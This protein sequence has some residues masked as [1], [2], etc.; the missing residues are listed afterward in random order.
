MSFE[1]FLKRKLD[2]KKAAEEMQTADGGAGG[3]R[4]KWSDLYKP[5]ADPTTGNAEVK[6]RFLPAK[7][8][9]GNIFVTRY[10]HFFKGDNGWVV[11]DICPTTHG[12]PCP[13]CDANSKLWNS[14][15][16]EEKNIARKRKRRKAYLF[17]VVV[18]ND[19]VQPKYNGTVQTMEIGY[20]IFQKI[21]AAMK[22]EFE[23]E[24]PKNPFDIFGGNNFIF[25]MKMDKAK[26][27]ITYEDSKFE[28]KAT[29]LFDGDKEKLKAVFENMAD[30]NF[31]LQPE[32]TQEKK[33][34]AKITCEAYSK[35]CPEIAAANPEYLKSKGVKAPATDFSADIPWDVSESA[36]APA[37]PAPTP[38]ETPAG[39][40]ESDM[41]FFKR[42]ASEAE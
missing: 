32:P 16:E 28:D 42:L 25:R 2:P 29:D 38:E 12:Q 23:S 5:K 11:M 7:E 37:A 40:E 14:G 21:M 15:D 34:W 30:L 13:I 27:Q 41:D 19:P 35:C 39:G 26:G 10:S 22:P 20:T 36:P 4:T 33:D 8:E 18:V 6:I 3:F 17:N 24:E 1:A 9:D 31:F